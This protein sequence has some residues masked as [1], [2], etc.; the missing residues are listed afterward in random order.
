MSEETPGKTPWYTAENVRFGTILLAI[1]LSALLTRVNGCDKGQ[2]ARSIL[3]D[4]SVSSLAPGQKAMQGQLSSISGRVDQVAQAQAAIQAG[5]TS[6]SGQTTALVQHSAHVVF[7]FDPH[8]QD[9]P[10]PAAL[11]RLQGLVQGGAVLSV[12]HRPAEGSGRSVAMACMSSAVDTNGNVLC[13]GPVVPAN[14]ELPDGRRYQ[15]VLRHDGTLTLAHWN[16]DGSNVQG[17][18]ELGKR[19]AVWIAATPMR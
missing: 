15:E 5:V 19:A 11:G 3:G 16:A 14:G 10:D 9:E 4:P 7:E 12:V 17:A 18:R 6:I 2:I 1:L 13:Q 8:A